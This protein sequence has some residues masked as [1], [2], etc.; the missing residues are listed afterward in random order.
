MTTTNGADADTDGAGAGAGGTPTPARSR[1][2]RRRTAVAAGIVSLGLVVI[3]L[4][5][6]LTP[7]GST[8][9][10]GTGTGVAGGERPPAAAGVVTVDAPPPPPAPGAPARRAP[11]PVPARAAD[12]SAPATLT[13]PDGSTAPV[14]TLAPH[15]GGVLDPPTDPARL[16]WWVHSALPGS[17]GGSVVVTGH[18]NWAGHTGFAHRWLPPASGG[19]TEPGQTVTLTTAAAGARRYRIT[20]TKAYPKTAGLPAEVNQHTGPETLLLITCGGHWTGGTLGYA[21]NLITTAV[22]A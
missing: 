11:A 13:L 3:G 20:G 15:R 19:R 8:N 18:I 6:A 2:R 1:V 21:D 12:T 4:A 10:T 5:V 14:D 16:G 9:D 17:G 7:A 22:P